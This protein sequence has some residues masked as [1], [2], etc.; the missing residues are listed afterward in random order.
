MG[1][2]AQ[3]GLAHKLKAAFLE[4]S[5]Q[6][7]ALQ[8]NAHAPRPATKQTRRR[9]SGLC[10]PHEVA[11]VAHRV[12]AKRKSC[13]RREP[14]EGPPGQLPEGWTGASAQRLAETQKP[15]RTHQK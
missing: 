3:Q 2:A 4:G 6:R 13:H 15:A 11:M 5:S 9:V 7:Q 10:N 12:S 14:G 1:F 8:Q